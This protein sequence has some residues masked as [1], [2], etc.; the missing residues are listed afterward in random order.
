MTWDIR[1][2]CQQCGGAIF[3]AEMHNVDSLGFS[4]REIT[5][6]DIRTT[7]REHEA[8]KHGGQSA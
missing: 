1:L 6:W 4:P 2:V 3:Q 8:E 7:M 5:I